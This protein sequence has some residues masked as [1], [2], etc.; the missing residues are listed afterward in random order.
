MEIQ[1]YDAVPSS[2]AQQAIDPN[3]M[4]PY[5][6]Q[7]AYAQQQVY[8]PYS[9][10]Q[11][12]DSELFGKPND[13]RVIQEYNREENMPLLARKHFW[14][15]ASKSIT[16]G[17]WKEQDYNDLWYRHNSIKLN[18][19]MSNPKHKY[20]F[21]DRLDL[22]QME[23]LVYSDFKRG[24]GMERYKV[25][26]RTL[27]ATSVTQNIQGVSHGGGSRKGGLISGLKNFFG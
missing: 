7:Q 1:E 5:A 12:G 3:S 14:S 21:K 8:D 15:L 2:H 26:E 23:L 16:L 9:G 6:A 27:Q 10:Q 4:S 19:I 13:L 20:T 11:Q 17:F 18:Y 24:V 25:N 22:L